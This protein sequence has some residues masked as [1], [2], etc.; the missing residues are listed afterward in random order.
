M[1]FVMP[2]GPCPARILIVDEAPSRE[3]ERLNMPLVGMSGKEF[4][5]MLKE[6][7]IVRSVCFATH[8]SRSCPPMGDAGLLVA[9]KKKE[10]TS[11]HA[12]INGKYV[13]QEVVQGIE[14]L[15]REIEMCRPNVII[16]L[17]NLSLFAL[18][19][20]WGIMSWR[21]SVIQTN[22]E[23]SLDYAPKVIPVI[24]P[25]KILQQWSWRQIAV[26]DLKRCLKES[27]REGVTPLNYSFLIR[28]NFIQTTFTLR[29]LQ[30]EISTTP[31]KVAVDIETRAGHI[32][33]IGLAWNKEEAICIPCMDSKNPEGY[34]TLGEEAELVFILYKLLTHPNCQVLGQNF[35]YDA[36]Y[37]WRH[38]F[39]IPNLFQ[40]TM[41]S[42]HVCFSN[43]Q[44]S[45]GFLSSMY[46]ENHVYWK[47]EG[48]EWDGKTG[49]DQLW[50]Y[51]CKDCV[52]TYEV[53]ESLQKTVDMMGLRKVH[54][55]QQSL[56]WPVLE[57]MNRGLRVDQQRRAVFAMELFEELSK[58]EQFFIDVLGY[59]LN[60]KSG[61]QMKELFYEQLNQ[62]EVFNRKTGTVS[63]DDE[64]LG[65]IANREP[66]LKPLINAI[67]E[68]RSLGVFLST[69]VRAPLDIDSRI[70]CSFNIA[71]TET[72]RFSSSK[73]AFGSGLNLQNIPK[74]G[75]GDSGL[76]L[77]NIRS[78]FIPD[79]GQTYFDIDLDSADLRIVAWEADL[80]EM[81]AML[82]EGK[83]VY[84]EVMKEYYHNP[85]MTKHDKQ[86]GTFKSLCHGMHYLGTPKGLAQRVGLDIHTVEK[87][88]KWYY[89][90]FPGLKKWQDY[91][92]DS[93]IKKRMVTNIFG[94]RCYFF[95]RIE[96]TIFNQAIAWIPQSTVACLINRGYKNIYDNLK[97]VRVLLQV[98][99]S[100]AGT[101]P[102]HQTEWCM[103]RIQ[104]E[105]AI[106][107]P[108]EDRLTIPVGIKSSTRSW[109]DCG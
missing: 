109:G 107:L 27:V 4:D 67:S 77:P 88:Y 74:G 1:S 42:Q 79:P 75:E 86:Y 87:L 94:Y 8:V 98:H 80:A 50:R 96:G 35:S 106:E 82:A 101:F 66:I 100:L 49:E 40:D 10:I 32:A 19:G 58:R 65:K 13:T 14:I 7:G 54:E 76:K 29:K 3:A 64:S 71:G 97:E 15:K 38:W 5:R 84:V 48:K 37:I 83:K 45:L 95:D 12:L 90:K 73:N 46:V 60:P 57:T 69:F 85:S 16:A 21:G 52:A 41:L 63:C 26:H 104:E 81:K 6:A 93:V 43:M 11:S 23:L 105:C 24:H 89:G 28:P 47:D 55:F 39:F 36:Q 33:C 25:K 22:L 34:W 59:Q 91:I 68:Y 103:K 2:S 18:T 31:T 72:Y 99:D 56:F 108:Y 92:K 9:Q 20:K 70:R 62:K 102:T 53:A 17:G 44:K 51:N 78:L 61:P 30:E